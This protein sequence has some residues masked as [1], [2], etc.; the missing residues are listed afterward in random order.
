MFSLV[1]GAAVRLR[2]PGDQATLHFF[3]LCLAFFGTFTFSFNGRLDRLDWVFYW[4]DAVSILLLP[5][6]FLHFTLV[7][8]ERPRSWLRS[9][10]GPALLPLLYAPALLLGLARVVAVAR[11]PMDARFF[12]G[13]IET[14][15]RFEPLYLALC[16][17]GR[18]ARAAARAVRGAVGHRAA[19]A[20]VDCLGHRARRDSVRAGLR[21]AVRARR[22]RHAADGAVGRAARVSCRSPSRPRSS[23]TG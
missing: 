23:A 18:A 13:V 21:A 8:P 17:A 5:P 14:L 22:S 6:L 4:A 10:L 3:W 11:A 12:S 20:A 7:F 2:R 16:F 19:P 1:V 9:S 15:D